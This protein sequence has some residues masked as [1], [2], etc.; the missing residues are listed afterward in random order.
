MFAR[1]Y[2]EIHSRKNQ[3]NQGKEI[4]KK[5]TGVTHNYSEFN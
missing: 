1:K 3:L 2:V 5:I 4:F